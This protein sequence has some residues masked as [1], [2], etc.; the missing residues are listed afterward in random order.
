MTSTDGTTSSAGVDS[1]T[2]A[3][4][5]M[6][7]KERDALLAAA[8]RH[9]HWGTLGLTA[10]WIEAGQAAVEDV[11]AAVAN[12]NVGRALAMTGLPAKTLLYDPD[13]G[14]FAHVFA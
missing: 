5:P 1:T 9:P 2:S 8:R 4:V 11:A 14:C 3:G 10:A 12:G 6:D 13:D 7:R